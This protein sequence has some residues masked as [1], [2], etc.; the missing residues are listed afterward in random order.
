MKTVCVIVVWIGKF[1]KDFSIWLNSIEKNPSVDF[2]VFTDQEFPQEIP[3][4]VCFVRSTLDDVRTKFEEN[5]KMNVRLNK[6]YK[7][8][9]YKPIWWMLMDDRLFDYD[10]WGYCDMDMVFGDIR[11]FLTDDFL[12]KYDKIFDR[13]YFTLYRNTEEMRNLYKRSLDKDNE[14]Y[15]YDKVFQTPYSC[16]FDEFM[17][18]GILSWK[19]KKAYVDQLDEK[20]IQDPDWK[21]LEFS[22]YMSEK[23][24]VFHWENGKLYRVDVDNHGRIAEPGSNDDKGEEQLLVHIQK[25]QLDLDTDMADANGLTSFWIY[26]NRYSGKK[27]EGELYSD[28]DIEQYSKV[29]RISEKKKKKESLFENGMIS[30]IPHYFRTRRIRKYTKIYKGYF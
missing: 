6:P 7:L 12:D 22:S 24:S 25:R 5:L 18:M 8:C 14:A 28:K 23:K 27:P 13:G 2:Y 10:Y 15:P 17:G 30:Y 19:Y 20:M 3:S 1:R 9:D 16:Y 29:V 11:K 4:N 26:P 21:R